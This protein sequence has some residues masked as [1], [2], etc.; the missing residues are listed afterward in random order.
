[1]KI[2]IVHNKYSQIGGEDINIDRE[3]KLLESEYVVES[4][5]YKNLDQSLVSNIKSL[6]FNSNN[7]VNVAFLKK[8]KEFKPDIVYVHNTWFTINLGIFSILK[9][10]NIDTVIKLHNF[11]FD[12][13]EGNHLRNS[14]LC[15]DCDGTRLNGI[16]NRCYQ[17]SY[18]MSALAT[19]YGLNYF[20]ILKNSNFKIL[21]LSEFHKEYLI[22]KGIDRE[23]IF[24]Y[25]NPLAI[26]EPIEHSLVDKNQLIYAGRI[27]NSKGLDLM[28]DSFL[29]TE[30]TYNLKLIGE[31]SMLQSL[32]EKYKNYS[33]IIFTGRMDNTETRKEISLSRASLFTSYMYEGQPV[34]LCESSELKVPSVFPDIGGIKE[35]FPKNYPL[36]YEYNSQS[37]LV[38]KLK[39][40]SD[41]KLMAK[42]QN[43]VS[44]HIL[45]LLNNET[46][47]NNFKGI[48][49]EQK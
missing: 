45:K 26:L 12:C 36:S 46:L 9:K 20:N 16:K 10:L 6:A 41:D 30:L 29:K 17:N 39:L 47:L 31:G 22:Q 32:K 1:V 4:F 44:E 27:D 35:F 7:S 5:I 37:D 13:A 38:K 14:K 25:F 11:R 28:I 18:V 15:H 2:L 21:V 48:L 33:N 43:L 34:F 3:I 8:L 49:N 24:K 19:K 23:K 40:L 42:C